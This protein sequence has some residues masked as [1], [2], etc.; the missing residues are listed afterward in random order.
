MPLDII[1][2][3]AL[4]VLAIILFAWERV[5][6][7]VAA[8]IIMSV[9]MLT[10]ILAPREGLSGFSNPATITIGALFI[11]SEGLRQTGTLNFIGRYFSMLGRRKRWGAF[12]FM[13]AAIGVISAFINNTAAVAIFIPIVIGVASQLKISPSKLLIPLAFTSMFGG[14]C[15]LIGTSANILVSSFAEESGLEPFSMF[16]FAPLGIIFFVIGF[17]YLLTIGYRFIPERRTIDELTSQFKIN[18][19]LADVV[20]EP[21]FAYLGRP[22]DDVPLARDLDLNVLKVFRGKDGQTDVDEEEP[23]EASPE[24]M[25]AR[26]ILKAGDM[27]R[28]R[29]SVRAIDTLLRRED[30]A[31]RPHSEWH[32]MDLERGAGALVEAVVAPDSSLE[33]KAIGE[34]DFE[35]RF[36]A[37]VLAMRHRGQLQQADLDDLRLS[38]GDSVLLAIDRKRARAI[39]QDPAFVLVS[40]VERLPYRPEKTRWAVAI[41]AGVVAAAALGLVP[42]VVS[43]AAGAVLLILTGCLTTEEAYQAVN[44]K[45]IFLLAGVLPLG[46]A[47][48]KT[49]AAAIL[50]E[51]LLSGLSPLGPTAVVSGIYFLSMILTNVISN[52]ATAVLMAPIALQMAEVMGVSASPLLIAVTFGATLALL[53]PVAPVNTLVFGPGQ[54]KFTDYA[55]VGAPLSLLFWILAT[56]LIPFFWPF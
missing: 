31:L 2:V 49:G 32:D 21:G 38:S 3:F 36:G 4:I 5:S 46:V 6:I 9:L 53:S 56:L 11:L 24:D 22:I 16:E 33:G 14:V 17:T 13:L 37:V 20:L 25:R 27:L 45:V 39:E 30:L 41:L 19:Y 26:H 1:T 35:A 7:D 51:A 15:T 10:G 50:S 52:Q 40:E 44:W 48:E 47:M 28:V 23:V 54:Y 43:A 29:G 34:V 55:R 18:E 12:V 42:I 8:I